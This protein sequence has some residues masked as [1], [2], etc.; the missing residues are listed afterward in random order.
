MTRNLRV[1]GRPSMTKPRRTQKKRGQ[2]MLHTE[3][4]GT[5][6]RAQ[7]SNIMKTEGLK[8]EAREAGGLAQW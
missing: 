5:Q 3:Q 7:D 8:P 4:S 2:Y 1:I 6:H